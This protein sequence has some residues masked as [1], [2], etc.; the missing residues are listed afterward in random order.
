MARAPSRRRGE[1]VSRASE[2]IERLFARRRT[3]HRGLWESAHGYVTPERGPSNPEV[4][5]RKFLP[6]VLL[7]SLY[8]YKEDSTACGCVTEEFS[9]PHLPRG[10]ARKIRSAGHTLPALLGACQC[11]TRMSSR[12]ASKLSS[13]SD[14]N[15]IRST[16]PAFS[17]FRTHSSSLRMFSRVFS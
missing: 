15:R 17:I 4:T 9:R 16:G 11:A 10:F 8:R 14:H 1:S 7:N 6:R 12:R 2:G 3:C 13:P 5:R